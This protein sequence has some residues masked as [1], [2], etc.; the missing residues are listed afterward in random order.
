VFSIE[1]DGDADIKITIM[2]AGEFGK[3]VAMPLWSWDGSDYDAL[4]SQVIHPR[5]S[6]WFV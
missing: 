6:V 1:T 2:F 5:A 4:R 3:R